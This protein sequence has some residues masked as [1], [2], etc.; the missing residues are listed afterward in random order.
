MAARGG[1]GG[2]SYARTPGDDRE[3]NW[4]DRAL[5]TDSQRLAHPVKWRKSAVMTDRWR[6]VNGRELFDI[7]SDP[8][9]RLD[10]AAAHPGVVSTLREAYEAWWTKGSRQ[11]DEEIPIAIGGPAARRLRLNTHDWRNE[12]CE[13]AWNQDLV[14][15]GLMCNGHWEVDVLEAGRYRFELRRWPVEEGA[16]IRAGLT[17]GAPVDFGQLRIGE[18]DSPGSADSPLR[19]RIRWGGGVALPVRRA[20]IA[21]AGREAEGKIAPQSDRVAFTLRLPAGPA[22]LQTWFDLDD[23]GSLG[24]YYLYVEQVGN[25]SNQ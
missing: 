22:H 9:Q 12:A 18:E 19:E 17:G 5:V 20:R 2:L 11:F 21:I 13:C 14:R 4:P 10:L 8:G 3:T 6:L 15:Q 16:G 1:A 25:F 24:A 7:K 23:G